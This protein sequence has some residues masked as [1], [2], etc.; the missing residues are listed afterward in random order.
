[1]A[2]KDTPTTGQPVVSEPN[3]EVTTQPETPDIPKVPESEQEAN[4]ESGMEQ[5]A[6]A[7][8]D[9]EDA[10]L[11]KRLNGAIS[12]VEKQNEELR[13]AINLQAELVQESPEFI[14][15]I[16]A[17][18]PEMANK[19]VQ[20]IW[21]GSGIRSYKQLIEAAKKEAELEEMKGKNP[22]LYETKKKMM[23]LESKLQEREQREQEAIR[24]KFFKKNNILENEYDPNYRKFQESLNL[25]NP[26]LIEKDYGKAL[27]LA[28]SLAFSKVKPMPVKEVEPPTVSV[29]G[30]KAPAVMPSTQPP[31]SE[32]SV[33]LSQQLET[34]RK[35][36]S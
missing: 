19:V 20:K 2:D 23:E 28:H 1:M 18:D 30:G 26:E 35:P 4:P 27:E 10:N 13:K 9:P 15:K 33:W 16:A 22:D 34:F 21:G 31:M 29:G 5:E 32:Q 3:A 8:E 14:H 36:K 12:K 24:T 17:T 11:K 7:Q 6:P 25:I